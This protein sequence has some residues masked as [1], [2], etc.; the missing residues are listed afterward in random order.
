[1]YI[2]CRYRMIKFNE[3]YRKMQKIKCRKKLVVARA[4]LRIFCCPIFVMIILTWFK[5]VVQ[6]ALLNP[7]M[8]HRKPC[9][10]NRNRN[11][12]QKVSVSFWLQFFTETLNST[13]IFWEVFEF[14]IKIG[15]VKLVRKLA[16]FGFQNFSFPEIKK[17]RKISREIPGNVKKLFLRF[18]FEICKALVLDLLSPFLFA[19]IDE[20]VSNL[21]HWQ[22]TIR[23][24][25]LNCYFSSVSKLTC[26][27]CLQL[28]GI[29][30]VDQAKLQ[31]SNDCNTNANNACAASSSHTSGVVHS[32]AHSEKETAGTSR[33][34]GEIDSAHAASDSDDAHEQDTVDSLQIG[35]RCV[36]FSSYFLIDSLD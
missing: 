21:W 26:L 6:S 35:L 19:F 29:H 1:M 36:S 15:S 22:Q 33:C 10:P 7:F 11:R 30:N 2:P 8:L 5:Y 14:R 18:R 23:P 20:S 27:A 17:A 16:I 4:R 34:R 25:C 13:F 32:A 31:A 28:L 24:F 3:F 9:K 12:N